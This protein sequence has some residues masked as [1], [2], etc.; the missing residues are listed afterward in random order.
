MLTPEDPRVAELYHLLRLAAGASDRQTDRIYEIF[1]LVAELVKLVPVEC[2]AALERRLP[3]DTIQAARNLLIEERPDGS[4]MFAFDQRKKF[5]LAPR[6]ADLL[7]FLALAERPKNCEEDALVGFRTRKEILI[8]LE[9][10]A[11]KRFRDQYVNNLV[12]LLKKTLRKHDER[13]LILSHRQK[14]VRLLLKH[15]GVQCLRSTPDREW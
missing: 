11:G 10:I 3:A 6:L 7:S 8:H 14:G 13:I 2:H 5:K 1:R 12:S 15:G 4:L 9:K